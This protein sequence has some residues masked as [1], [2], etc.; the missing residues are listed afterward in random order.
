LSTE[1][2]R[3]AFRDK[4]RR[5]RRDGAPEREPEEGLPFWLRERLAR[6]RAQAGAVARPP[7]PAPTSGA[8]GELRVDAGAEGA[9]AWRETPLDGGHTH[10]GWRLCEVRDAEPA[11]LS[12]LSGDPGLARV[13][14]ARAVYLDTETSGLSGGAGVYVYLV[15][16]G[17]FDGERFRVWQGFLRDPAEERALLAEV[18]RRLAQG[19]AIVSFFGK[20]FDRHRLEDKMRIAG[21]D[22][23]FAGVPHLDLFAPCRRLTRGT[24]PD[25]R[26]RTLESTLCGLER[27]DDLPG[28]FAPEAWFD[29]LAGRPHRLEGVFRHNL[30]DVLSLVTL[31]AYVGRAAREERGDGRPLAGCARTRA[32]ALA[33][34]HHAAGARA[35]ALRW[36]EESIARGSA[37]GLE[38]RELLFE[39]ADLL[40]RMRRDEEARRALEDLL[41]GA[42]DSW[43]AR[44]RIELAKLL[45]HRFGELERALELCEEARRLV[46]ARHAGRERARLLA[47]L[48]RREPR[49]AK[50]LARG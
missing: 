10:G 3:D 28:A 39:R 8:P 33:R 9:V 27:E 7:G 16:L 15:G 17:T 41:A 12:L 44:C 37:L 22:S 42:P 32:R 4:L 2:D 35:E 47:D 24:L 34:A 11:T 26:L 23:P 5:L 50:K 43:S 45:E 38:S 49:L 14:L 18:A 1:T 30:D 19:A 40:R 29:F 13:D 6:R 20:S 36:L 25:A 48:A 46:D 21:V 31:A